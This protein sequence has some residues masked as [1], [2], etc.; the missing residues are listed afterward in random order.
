MEKKRI[1]SAFLLFIALILA[2]CFLWA[3]GGSESDGEKSENIELKVWING[4]DSF[5]GPE[6]QKLPQEQWYISQAFKRFEEQNP[7]VS[8]ELTVP[9]DQEGAHQSFKAASLAGNA[10]DIA[11]LWTGQPIF[12][13]KDV[14]LPLDD[15]VPADDLQKLNGWEGLRYNFD[16]NGEILGYPAGQNQICFLLYN[17]SIVKQAGLDFEANPPRTFEAFDAACESIKD[18]GVTPII[19][20]ESFPWFFAFIGQYWWVQ[21]TGMEGIISET[22]GD[23]KFSD[24][25]AF[26]DALEYYNSLYEKGYFN[27]DMGTSA[28]GWNRFLQGKGAMYPAVTSFLADAEST[29]GD[30]V[31]LLFPPDAPGAKI[32]NST[33]GGPGQSLVISKDTKY[34]EMALKLVSF[35]NSKEEVMISQGI[36]PVPPVRNDMS[37]EELGWNEN[38]GIMKTIPYSKNY[39]YWPDNLLPG[40]VAEVYYKQAPLVALGVMTPE[41]FAEAMDKSVSNK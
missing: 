20:N 3:G 14:L 15:Y 24:D 1:I 23:K 22:L 6:E 16:Q 38:A 8:I 25:Q 35:L 10:P 7:G 21:I 29:L 19:S 31:G 40:P 27:E 5:I 37:V 9:P 41:E 18:L 33:I 26:L 11:N 4:S 39:I 28:D 13:L 17:K 36:M 32:V 2:P 34:P 12:A 30:N